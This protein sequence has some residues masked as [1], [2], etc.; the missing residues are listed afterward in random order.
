MESMQKGVHGQVF[1]ISIEDQ[2]Y[3]VKRLKTHTEARRNAAIREAEI[4]SNSAHPHIIKFHSCEAHT[5]YIDIL[6]EYAA[7][8]DLQSLLDL[9]R[10]RHSLISEKDIWQYAYEI[11]SALD[12]L[13]EKGLVH[14]D[15][16]CA[17]VFMTAENHVKVGDFGSCG[18]AALVQ[19][20]GTPT[21]HSPEQVQRQALDCKVDIWAL[22]CLLYSLAAL[23]HPFK[24]DNLAKIQ[25]A[26]LHKTPNAL[27]RGYSKRLSSFISLLLAKRALDRPTASAAIAIIPLYYRPTCPSPQLPPPCPV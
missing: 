13:H 22:G 2:K 15:L 18:E 25:R 27:P 1:V 20:L 19:S 7:G 17:N 5:D 11:L 6:M 21:Y 9:S 10:A 12:Y 24:G 26:I 8:G 3:A 4:L 23:E 14:G 16:K